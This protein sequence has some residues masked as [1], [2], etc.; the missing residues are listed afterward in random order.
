LFKCFE[1]FRDLLGILKDERV[2][3]RDRRRGVEDERDTALEELQ[4]LRESTDACGQRAAAAEEALEQLRAERQADH[5]KLTM[6]ET[7]REAHDKLVAELSAAR[8]AKADAKR[9]MGEMRSEMISMTES[10]QALW[11]QVRAWAKGDSG[12]G[13]AERLSH[14]KAELERLMANNNSSAGSPRL[15]SHRE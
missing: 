2:C 4:T 15:P 1:S 12:E 8:E 13:M 14:L 6:A 3:L 7:M 11:E 10:L 9:I 5:E